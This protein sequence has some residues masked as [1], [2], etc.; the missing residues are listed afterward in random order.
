M[1]RKMSVPVIAIASVDRI[2]TLCNTKF[3]PSYDSVYVL[4]AEISPSSGSVPS[5][6]LIL[7][8]PREFKLIVQA[9]VLTVVNLMRTCIPS[10]YAAGTGARV[11]VYVS[12]PSEDMA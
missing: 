9:P 5:K 11:A 7:F 12:V 1:N 3:V 4:P 8:A 2:A 10:T 6:S